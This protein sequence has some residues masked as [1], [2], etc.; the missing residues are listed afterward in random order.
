MKSAQTHPRVRVAVGDGRLR[1][2]AVVLNSD[3]LEADI[4]WVAM[5]KASVPFLV[6]S[7]AFAD[8]HHVTTSTHISA[9]RDDLRV[10]IK[11]VQCTSLHLQRY[12][13][14]IARDIHN[15]ASTSDRQGR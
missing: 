15:P 14:T 11:S 13:H 10:D 3:G 1:G 9:N 5:R 6:R 7:L 2:D 4:G 8:L 12:T